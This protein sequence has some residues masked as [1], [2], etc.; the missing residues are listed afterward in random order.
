MAQER[1]FRVLLLVGNCIRVDA[2][3]MLKLI[4]LKCQENYISKR[5]ILKLPYLVIQM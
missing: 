2:G 1:L 5:N 4:K 3:E